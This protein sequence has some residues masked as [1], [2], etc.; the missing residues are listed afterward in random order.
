MDNVYWDYEKLDENGAVKSAPYHDLDGAVTGHKVLNLKAWLDENPQERI[1]LGYIKHIRPK[2]N[3]VEYN[4]QTQYLAKST[5]QIDEYTV[6]DVYHV[7]N[8]SEEQMALE[9][10]L[11]GLESIEG[12]GG[13]VFF[14]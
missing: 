1:R 7:M 8:K 6:E 10:M 13:I 5:R 12:A 11:Q 9:E 4:H 2:S 3:S 14:Q